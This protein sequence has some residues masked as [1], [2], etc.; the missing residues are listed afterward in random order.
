MP[1]W[2]GSDFTILDTDDQI[3]L[4]KQL[5]EAENIDEKRWPAAPSPPSSTAGKPRPA[6]R[7]CP[8]PPTMAA[9]LRQWQGPRPLCQYQQRLKSLNA[10]DFGDLLLETSASSRAQRRPRRIPPP[11]P[12]HA[13][14]RIPGHQHRPVHLA[15][16]ARPG[17]GARE[18]QYLRRR[19]RR[20]VDLWLARRRGRQHPALEK[21]FPGA[22]VIRLERNYR[23]TSNILRAAS[24][25]SPTMRPPRQDVADRCR[26]N[27]RSGRRH[28]GLGQ[29]R[30]SPPGRREI[31]Q[32]R[33]QGAN[34]TTSPSLSA[35][36]PDAR[37]RRALHHPGPQL[38]RRRRPA[39]YERKEI[40]RRPRLS[41]PHFQSQR[42][43][44]LRAHHQRAQ[45]RHRRPGRQNRCSTP[46]PPSQSLFGATAHL[47][48]TGGPKP[49]LR[50][51][52]IVC[53][54]D[55]RT[56]PFDN[57]TGPAAAKWK[58]PHAE[59]RRADPR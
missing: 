35:P 7:R 53:A 10:A 27:R 32:L 4:M 50:P 9:G 12:L 58:L 52:A 42:R 24:I 47:I 13:G 55:V 14:R 39:L 2:L 21:D 18:R 31:E 41:A 37:I 3:R 29:R 30:G 38:S 33:H 17:P 45:A 43:P 28:L 25:S 40:P 36:P 6:A 1:N 11:L 54:T 19:R 15:A 26:G 51:C 44:R 57:W 5:L 59:A 48:G 34:S 46:A 16:P 23:S 22:K 49:R 20:P 56:A 8:A